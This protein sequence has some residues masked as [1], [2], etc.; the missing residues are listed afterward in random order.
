[1]DSSGL[2]QAPL[3]RSYGNVNEPPSYIESSEL[4]DQL[5]DY[6]LFNGLCPM[7][8]LTQLTLHF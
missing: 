3:T 2:T 7:E 1:M 6:Q 4:I 8:L 5:S